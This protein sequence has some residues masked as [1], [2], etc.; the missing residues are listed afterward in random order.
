MSET[1]PLAASAMIDEENALE[2]Q[3]RI[4]EAMARYD[5][6]PLYARAHLNRGISSSPV[7]N[8]L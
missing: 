5:A 6:N 3:G 7:A 4:S 1:N 2:E 8:A